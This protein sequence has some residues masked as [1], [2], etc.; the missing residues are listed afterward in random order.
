MIWNSSSHNWVSCP[1]NLNFPPFCVQPFI[2]WSNCS[3]YLHN[4]QPKVNTLHD[5]VRCLDHNYKHA[6]CFKG[7]TIKTSVSDC[8]FININLI[9]YHVIRQYQ[10]LV[11][12]YN[13]K[14]RIRKSILEKDKYFKTS[15]QNIYHSQAQIL[16]CTW[17]LVLHY[18]TIY[19]REK[20]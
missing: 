12:T 3:E 19:F 2:M 10:F 4:Q 13:L 5:A 1:R 8:L 18:K 17:Y 6:A 9:L 15:F 16:F 14:S 7:F 20:F 11:Y